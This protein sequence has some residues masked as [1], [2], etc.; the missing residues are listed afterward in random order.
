MLFA[1][2]LVYTVVI[3][4]AACVLIDA[5]AATLQKLLIGGTLHLFRVPYPKGKNGN[6]LLRLRCPSVVCLPIYVCR[7]DVSH[8]PRYL[9]R[10]NFYRRSICPAGITT[11]A[12]KYNK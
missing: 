5:P 7:Q 11:N 6:L 2:D 10:Y 1:S 4:V 3:S 12:K 9:D 8:E